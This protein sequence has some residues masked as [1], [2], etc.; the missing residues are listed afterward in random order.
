MPLNLTI[1]R[2]LNQMAAKITTEGKCKIWAICE[3]DGNNAILNFRSFESK[4]FNRGLV[5]FKVNFNYKYYVF[6]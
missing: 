4:C 6:Y 3:M 1:R 2:I 5:Y